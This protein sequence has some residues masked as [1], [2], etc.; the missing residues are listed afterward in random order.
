MLLQFQSRLTHW[1]WLFSAPVNRSITFGAL[2]AITITLAIWKVSK[3]Q[4]RIL[5][6]H[7]TIDARCWL[8]TW[9][10][11]IRRCTATVDTCLSLSSLNT[12][13]SKKAFI[14]GTPAG[15]SKCLEN[16]SLWTGEYI[17]LLS[18]EC[19]MRDRLTGRLMLILTSG[20][21]AAT[22]MAAG[23]NAIKALRA[24]VKCIVILLLDSWL[25]MVFPLTQGKCVRR[26]ILWRGRER[27]SSVS[28]IYTFSEHGYGVQEFMNGDH[29]G[30]FPVA[31]STL[32]RGR[33][34]CLERRRF[35]P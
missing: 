23:S 6:R 4:F 20:S 28:L 27:G 31:S 21:G 30:Q 15:A 26:E 19:E 8:T 9:R 18:N 3:C 25:W 13:I 12:L 22:L 29:I 1:L 5:Q 16:A 33:W 34:D 17:A 10:I 24:M 7:G 14:Y 32:S 2:R 11:L 35:L